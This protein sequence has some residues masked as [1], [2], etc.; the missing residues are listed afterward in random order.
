MCP[1]LLGAKR[2]RGPQSKAPLPLACEI[3]SL[4]MSSFFAHFT[5]LTS[6]PFI[7]F[8]Q[9]L[10]NQTLQFT[11]YTSLSLLCLLLSLSL[12][13]CQNLC[14]FP[15]LMAVHGPTCSILPSNTYLKPLT[16]TY[17]HPHLRTYESI[18]FRIKFI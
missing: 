16:V 2:K 12:S 1:I 9:T 8:Q 14:H 15:S 13:W 5:S 4:F 17:S 7:S 3:A 18:H 11:I 6:V 10:H